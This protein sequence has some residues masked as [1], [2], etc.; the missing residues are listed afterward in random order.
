MHP[1]TGRVCVP[2]DPARADEFDPLAVPTVTQLLSEI[3]HWDDRPTTT[4]TATTATATAAATISSST[5]APAGEEEKKV[6]DVDKTS[7]KPYVDY[8]RRFVAALLK[9]EMA[10]SKKLAQVQ[11]LGS[12]RERPTAARADAMEF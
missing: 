3:D 7:L 2:I 6:A 1:G 10:D 5:A 9:E 4:T 11:A 8:F 12:K